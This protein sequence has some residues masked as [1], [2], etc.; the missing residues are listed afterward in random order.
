MSDQI[1]GAITGVTLSGV[2]EILVKILLLLLCVM[3]LLVLKQVSMMNKVV[4]I[5]IANWFRAIAWG[6]FFVTVFV[7]AVIFVI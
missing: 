5:P 6:Y 7:T 1:V 4:N 2:V 3:S